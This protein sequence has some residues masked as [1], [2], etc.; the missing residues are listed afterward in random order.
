MPLANFG[1]SHPK[2]KTSAIHSFE[3]I[4][5]VFSIA[6]D[7]KLGQYFI[8]TLLYFYFPHFQLLAEDH[9]HVI[10][11]EH[12]GIWHWNTQTFSKLEIIF[13]FYPQ[14]GY[15]CFLVVH[16]GRMQNWTSD[17]RSRSGVCKINKEQLS[18]KDLNLQK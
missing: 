15:K 7:P 16:C 13:C 8:N 5:V 11:M 6:I 12:V 18:G 1:I 17:L 9:R 14:M 3:W 10:D 2:K 4:Y